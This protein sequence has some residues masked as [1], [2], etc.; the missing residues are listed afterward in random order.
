MYFRPSILVLVLLAAGAAAQERGSDV[1]E[2]S[3]LGNLDRID[4]QQE[5]SEAEAD[6][7]AAS[8]CVIQARLALGRDDRAAALRHYQRAWR[9]DPRQ[10]ALLQEIV[11]LA[12]R[13]KR[14][15]EAARYAA[16]AAEGDLGE[17]LL[18][19][20]LA[21]HLTERRDWPRAIQLYE[22]AQRLENERRAQPEQPDLGAVLIGRE[23]GRLYFLTGDFAN[24]AKAFG[25]VRD[26]VANADSK[27]SDD[28][29]QLVLGNAA[30][31]YRLWA[32]AF[33][34]AGRFEEAEALLRK[35]HEA[36]AN[37]PLLAFRLARLAAQRG[38]A[39]A[40]RE[41][42]DEYFAAKSDAAGDEPYALLTTL[43]ADQAG[44][45]TAA[46]KLTM[47]RL[48]RLAGE[49]PENLALKQA[50]A[51]Q[52]LAAEQWEKA[53]PLL[54][55]IVAKEPQSEAAGDLAEVY[56]RTDQVEKLLNLAA[57]T[58]T[59][60]GS[61]DA[62]GAAALAIGAD[63]PLV[64]RLAEL[65]HRQPDR[66]GALHAAGWLALQAKDN[67]AAE[68]LL[69]AAAAKAPGSKAAIYLRWGLELLLA[70][71][72]ARAAVVFQRMLDEKVSPDA[73][74]DTQFHLAAA[75][76]LADR[77]DEALIAARRAVE[78]R[79]SDLRAK[80]RIGWVLFQGERLTEARQAYLDFL[81]QFD[82]RHG[83]PSVRDAVREA[84]LA[85][86]NIELELGN[87]PAATERLQEV[88]DEFP[89]DIAAGNDLGYLWADRGEHLAR[90]LALI[91]RAVK[92]DPESIA[93]RD[94]LGWVYFRLKRLEE[95]A[96]ELQ[97]AAAGKS[98]DGTILDHLGQALLQLDKR[99]EALSAF[100][101]AEAA[102]QKAGETKELEAVRARIQELEESRTNEP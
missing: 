84:R 21:T 76:A 77:T 43:I 18:L 86:S 42:L 62:L 66:P 71:E 79:P 90:A 99:D 13:L 16:L 91:E 8:V 57:Q 72:P 88:L 3:P 59:K 24:A 32:E 97:K 63:K 87:F 67:D 5:R 95:A 33:L 40:A 74:A 52:Y 56:R 47:E 2:Q 75:L 85:L 14:A 41:K 101:R 94:S 49:D 92:A 83:L 9:W 100:R 93:Y 25:T 102:F 1:P 4:P 6:R 80:S 96:A 31:T 64:T 60:T 35:S 81:E 38:D 69:A 28:A 53:E 36:K 15:D 55:A 45:A 58:A 65:A 46:Q 23:M 73:E 7:V 70:D 50:L 26:A 30:E 34:A 19:R 44:D 17:P 78:L 51:Q 22:Q 37:V 29:R 11:E 68:D 82:S 89:E 54:A 20:R 61:L 12:F 10:A 98:P 27:L 48:E 39:R